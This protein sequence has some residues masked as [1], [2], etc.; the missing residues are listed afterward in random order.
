MYRFVEI[1]W[2]P[3]TQGIVPYVI[4]PGSKATGYMP[5]PRVVPH[6]RGTILYRRTE[7]YGTEYGFR[8]HK[9]NGLSDAVSGV[10]PKVFF[11]GF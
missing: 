3:W 6:G 9:E 10:D 11:Y 4:V 7:N 8:A 1:S 5:Y 2:T